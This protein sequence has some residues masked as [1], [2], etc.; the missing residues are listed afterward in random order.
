MLTEAPPQTK[1][2]SRIERIDA[3]RGLALLGII[4]ANIGSFTDYDA[5]PPEQRQALGYTFLSDMLNMLNSVLIDTKFLTIF[6]ILFGVGFSVMLTNAQTGR[7]NGRTDNFRTY[8]LWRM[9]VLL[10]IGCVHAWLLWW[11]D[12]LRNYA[13]VGMLLVLTVNWSDK[14]VL[15]IGIVC[16]VFLTGAVFILNAAL[17]LQEYPYDIAQL[18][19]I[20][21]TGTYWDVVGAN[22]TIDPLRNFVQDSPLTFATITGRVLLGV[23]LGR[24]GYFRHPDRFRQL[25]N[26]WLG[27][28]FSVGLL[29]SIAFW[30]LRHGKLDL[31]S[32]WL[33]WVP[34][35]VA[36]GMLLH[37]LAYI[38]LFM[39]LYERLRTQRW[40][41]L[42][43]PVG[44]MSLSNYL[45]Q[46]VFG[47]AL[48]YGWPHGPQ[49]M[50]RVN[51][52]TG[53]GI[54]LGIYALQVLLSRWWLHRYGQGPVERLWR[55]LAPAYV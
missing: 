29:A 40:L 18:Y 36:G 45:L 22:W 26:R 34:F 5:L 15:R 28:G 47:V 41:R 46:S 24:I 50:G 2:Q 16:A 25:T 51:G 23:W 43:V 3:L 35:A 38:A 33:V 31:D 53:I 20:F 8:F 44:R 55:W 1:S 42:F 30:A 14:W 19:Q 54:A 49:L 48:F 32:P 21:R 11:G 39:R 27:W 52:V 12:I 17:S 37:A 9:T 13:L 4:L 7:S 6:S 10:L